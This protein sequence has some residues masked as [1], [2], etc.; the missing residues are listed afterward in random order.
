MEDLRPKKTENFRSSLALYDSP[1]CMIIRQSEHPSTCFT[2]FDLLHILT[3]KINEFLYSYDIQTHLLS[4]I[5]SRVSK[6]IQ[7]S[8]F[9]LI[10]CNDVILL[11]T[12]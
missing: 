4:N 8:K 5:T 2:T 6:I 7:N 9:H 11:P 10:V 3:F 12:N 1:R